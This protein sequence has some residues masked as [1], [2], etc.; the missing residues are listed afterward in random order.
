MRASAQPTCSRSSGEGSSWR[1]P[2]PRGWPASWGVAEGD[3]DI[4][5]PALVADAADRAA[6]QAVVE[7][8]L[9]PGE[10]GRQRRRVEAVAHAK[11]GSPMLGKAVPGA[12]QL[13][14][15]AA[16]DAVADQGPQRDR[17]GALQFDGQVGNAQRASTS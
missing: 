9:A 10:E 15:V 6:G 1:E 4:A 14:V 5:Q 7:F 13:A 17:D 12:A 3:G 16:V 11:S 2:V 8:L